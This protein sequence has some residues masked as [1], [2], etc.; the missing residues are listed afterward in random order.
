MKASANAKISGS[1][2]GHNIGWYSAKGEREV[3]GNEIRVIIQGSESIIN[4]KISGLPFQIALYL[5]LCMYIINC[6]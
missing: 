4:F 2:K 1:V 5:Y 6:V 3:P